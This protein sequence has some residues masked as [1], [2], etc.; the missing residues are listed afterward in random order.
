MRRVKWNNRLSGRFYHAEK[1][2]KPEL[3][4]RFQSKTDPSSKNTFFLAILLIKHYSDSF[5][6]AIGSTHDGIALIPLL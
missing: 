5:L 4:R 2:I 6:C 1:L 3:A